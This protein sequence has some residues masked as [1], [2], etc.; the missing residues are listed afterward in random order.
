MGYLL[1]NENFE[2]KGLSKT[3]T[4]ILTSKDKLLS[5]LSFTHP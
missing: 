3:N 2:C 1:Y 4:I 5:G